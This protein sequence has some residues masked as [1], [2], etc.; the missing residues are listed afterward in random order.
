VENAKR[1]ITAILLAVAVMVVGCEA[2]PVAMPERMGIGLGH[3]TEYGIWVELKPTE[4][5]SADE[6]YLVKL[7]EN[8]QSRATAV[9]SWNQL[10]LGVLR[11]KTVFFP[12]TEAELVAYHD[13]NVSHIFKV[14]VQSTPVTVPNASLITCDAYLAETAFGT[15]INGAVTNN[16]EWPIGY[17]R[18]KIELLDEDYQVINCFYLSVS[19]NIIAPGERGTFDETE[20]FARPY[21]YS[22][23]YWRYQP[24]WEWIPP[25]PIS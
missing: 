13:Q 2:S 15:R 7:Y 9:V 22:S 5:A 14:N 4:H 6:A 23:R 25:Q 1:V 8:G 11:T 24:E 20:R 19:P 3:Y 21:E 17:V 12:A 18:I 16:C 10:E